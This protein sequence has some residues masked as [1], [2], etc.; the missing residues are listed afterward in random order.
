MPNVTHSSTPNSPIPPSAAV[1]AHLRKAQEHADSMG[2]E[3]SAAAQKA[4][5]PFDAQRLAAL[6]RAATSIDFAL[7]LIRRQHHAQ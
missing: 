3:L 7:A 4:T 2:A 6:A 1:A 5:R